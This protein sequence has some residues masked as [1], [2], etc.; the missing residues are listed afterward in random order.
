MDPQNNV[1]AC[2][3]ACAAFNKE[4]YCCSGAHSTPQTCS[5]TTYSMTFKKLALTPID[6]LTTMKLVR[7]LLQE[8]TT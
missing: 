7:S 5:P 3:S 2:K 1:V 8:L 6:T 4:E